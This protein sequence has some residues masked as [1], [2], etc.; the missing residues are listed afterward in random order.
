MAKTKNKTT[1]TTEELDGVIAEISDQVADYLR[2][3][4]AALAKAMPG[5][6]DEES[7]GSEGPAAPE[8][9]EAAPEDEASPA[10]EGSAP[11]DAAPPAEEGSAPDMGAA[12][13]EGDQ[14]GQEQA[15]EPA[16]TVEQLQAEYMNLDPEA[17][18]LHYL[19]CKG[20]IMAAMGGQG[21]PAD[22]PQAPPA[23][24]PAAPPMAAPEASAPPAMKGEMPSTEGNGGEIKAGKLGKS[25]S[26]EVAALKAE[27]AAQADSLAKNEQAL[28]Q[29]V[30]MVA[31]P[32]RKSVK[33]ISELAFLSKD[34]QEATTAALPLTKSEIMSTLREK[35]KTDTTLKK[36]DR[37]LINKFALGQADAKSIAH[38]LASK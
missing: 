28:M 32:L 10:D 35:A 3:D 38:L 20:A 9:S 25:E 29:L 36:S 15:I 27:L 21:S 26:A 34:G 19:A 33:G 11:A 30:E 24:P 37:D 31:K 13:P 17:L 23:A 1:F 16:P 12:P 14:A 18:K 22:A 8:A 7:E 2:K 5:E 6:P 4:E